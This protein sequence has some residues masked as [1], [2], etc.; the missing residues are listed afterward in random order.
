[1]MPTFA[2]RLRDAPRRVLPPLRRLAPG[3]FIL[4]FSIYAYCANPTVTFSSVGGITVTANSGT[5][6]NLNGLGVGTL[7]T[8][9]S[10]FAPS[11]TPPIT[12]AFYYS[13]IDVTVGGLSAGATGLLTAYASTNFG[14]PVALTGYTCTTGCTGS[15]GSYT[16]LPVSPASPTTIAAATTGTVEVWLGVFVSSTNGTNGYSGADSIKIT[17]TVTDSKNG[18]KG[19]KVFTLNATAQTAVEMA[20]STATGGL[21]LS[22]AS[23]FAMNFL[24]VNGLG[25]NPA[26]G[27]TATSVSGGYVYHTPYTITPIFSGFTATTTGTVKVK[28]NTGFGSPTMI[29]LE[30][31]A[32][33]SG[34]YSAITTTAQTITT[35]GSNTGVTRY[36]GLFVSNANGAGA[37]TGSDSSTLT[38]IL[39]VP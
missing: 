14:H 30:D 12:G 22:P 24:N 25:I 11:P 5:L 27:L 16:P 32:S 8:G 13:P 23:D 39:T 2:K 21:T 4:A 3:I 17:F 9:T 20:L 33:S 36:L 31:S 38:Y 10:L 7:S 34:P 28:L 15:S 29:Y 37:F 26:P 35:T 1:M 18:K 6:G 19:T